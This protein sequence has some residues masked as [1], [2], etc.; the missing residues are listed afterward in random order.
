MKAWIL[1]QA[2]V[3]IMFQGDEIGICKDNEFSNVE[4]ESACLDPS[5]NR[6]G[7]DRDCI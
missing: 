6:A 5:E 3:G 1:S 4:D 2:V 7:S